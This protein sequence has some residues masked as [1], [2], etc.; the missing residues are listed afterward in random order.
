MEVLRDGEFSLTIAGDQLARGNRPTAKATRNNQFLV[1]CKGMVGLEGV[2]QTL[3]DIS[4]H[5]I[6]LHITITDG[7]PYPQI[8]VFTN[9]VIVCSLTKIYEYAGG[10][11]SA[12]KIT[13]T[14]GSTWSAVD[15]YDFIYLSNSK[16]AVVR[17]ATTGLYS[18]STTL[19]KAS[20][21]CNFNGQVHV[22]A[23]DETV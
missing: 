9:L 8:F 15:F 16:V 21:I 18:L 23:P 20:T 17:D 13:V 19:P 22:G 4:S 11:L 2:L 14:A 5:W 1:E 7:F 12:A 3:D 6:D 10:V